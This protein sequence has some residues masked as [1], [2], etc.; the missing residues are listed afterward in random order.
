[1]R[2]P[3]IFSGGSPMNLRNLTRYKLSIIGASLFSIG[4]MMV[5]LVG[6]TSSAAAAPKRPTRTPT[7][8]IVPAATATPVSNPT[9]NVPGT[10][11][12]VNSPSL[13]FGPNVLRS[14]A[15][16]SR[17][18]VWA[19]GYGLIEH[20]NGANWSLVPAA[21][22][23]NPPDFKSVTAVASND[24]WAV[25]RRQ[26][27]TSQGYQKTLVEHWDGSAWT[28]VPSPNGSALTAELLGVD[29]V[30]ANDIWAVGNSS[31]P[32]PSY[33][34]TTLIQHWDG[35]SWSIVPSPNPSGGS[36]NSLAGVAVVSAND[37]WAVGS[38]IGSTNKTLIEHWDGSSW[39]IVPSPNV[40]PYGN[41]LFGVAA[42]AAND[43]WAVGATNNGG[44]SLILHWDGASWSVVPSPSISDWTN[45]LQSVTAVAV[46]DVWAVGVATFTWYI[47]DGDPITS[48]QTIIQHW[49]GTAWSI[50]PSPNPG[51]GNNYYGTITNELYGVAAV[52]ASDVWAVGMYGKSD[53]LNVTSQTLI[54]RYTVP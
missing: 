16:V 45:Q 34:Q 17:D 6:G 49:N 10:W 11:K 1:V 8:I 51:D 25:G 28:V 24:V 13:S 53:G 18:D 5:M 14:V 39:S 50:V 32:A 9:P 54:E 31:A 41:Y 48:S 23:G 46:D 7:P 4:L 3:K 30:S 52:S 26:E 38:Y 29:A 2:P 15:A 47:S 21:P 43:V 35:S 19:V 37:V 20:W 33:A 22:G 36:F 12:V 27:T 40:G 42:R 44:N